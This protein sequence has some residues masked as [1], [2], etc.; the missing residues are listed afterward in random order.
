MK[1]C[2]ALWRY[3]GLLREHSESGF[4]DGFALGFRADTAQYFLYNLAEPLQ[5]E[6]ESTYPPFSQ[7]RNQK[8]IGKSH[9]LKTSEPLQINDSVPTA[10]ENMKLIL[11]Y[12]V[13]PVHSIT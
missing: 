8:D 3:E 9:G 10:E 11:N 5:R 6:N 1:S 13:C 12:T 7:P 4:N 2:D